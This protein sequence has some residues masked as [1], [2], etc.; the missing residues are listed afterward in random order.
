MMNEFQFLVQLTE[1]PRGS[2]QCHSDAAYETYGSVHVVAFKTVGDYKFSDHRRI[3]TPEPRDRLQILLFRIIL[4]NKG[5][6][7]V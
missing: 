3:W 7:A 2:S 6:R 1:F 4:D 5:M